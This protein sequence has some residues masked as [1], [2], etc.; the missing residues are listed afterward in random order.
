MLQDL[1]NKLKNKIFERKNKWM[2]QLQ[3]KKNLALKTLLLSLTLLGGVYTFITFAKES[4][5]EEV[6]TVKKPLPNDI[7]NI[8][9]KQIEDKKQLQ[10]QYTP[11]DVSVWEPRADFLNL[12]T[13]FPEDADTSDP[14]Q[15]YAAMIF[16]ELIETDGA[17]YSQVIS[18]LDDKPEQMASK[19]GKQRQS[20][21]GKYNITDKEQ[22]PLNKDTWTVKKWDD[23][24]VK[25]RDANGVDLQNHSNLK[26]IMAMANVYGYY[27]HWDDE[28]Q[29]LNYT[30]QLL[31]ASKSYQFSMSDISFEKEMLTDAEIIKAREKGNGQTL[32]DAIQAANYVNDVQ[33]PENS[34]LASPSDAVSDTAPNA[35]PN[36]DTEQE[37]DTPK[38]TSGIGDSVPPTDA[39]DNKNTDRNT[40]TET[41]SVG[42]ETT[43]SLDTSSSTDEGESG[44]QNSADTE[45]ISTSTSPLDEFSLDTD[46]N[47]RF[48]KNTGKLD[49]KLDLTV[50]QLNG[51]NSLY[52]LDSIGNSA[53]NFNEH[54]QGWTEDKK[55]LV[56]AMVLQNWYAEYGINSNSF[57]TAK[58]LSKLE[59]DTY[60]AELPS[61]LSEVRRNVIKTAL[62]S[63][64]YIP[65]Y[66]GG[67]PISN[68]YERNQFHNIVAPDYKGR[69]FRGLDCSGWVNYV[70]WSATGSKPAA[71]STGAFLHSGH[72]IDK[73]NLRPGDVLV[74]G[75]FEETVGHIV[76]FLKWN[77]DG[78]MKVIE[79]TGFPQNNV[80]ISDMDISWS[81]RN[82]LD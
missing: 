75:G 36:T 31:L 73:A 64:G 78:S 50:Y 35:E 65:Y 76:I 37:S 40:S 61:D 17:W 80:T 9:A 14:T 32:L 24:I 13:K 60:L 62:Q 82:I 26:E 46:G 30:K 2:T 52:T 28:E 43:S 12:I 54:W 11:I 7:L 41:E 5:V 53:E 74:R 4:K 42:I 69:V 39:F 34:T 23:V 3:G 68:E 6:V 29:F 56:D 47:V 55:A 25:V 49:L 51:K 16:K 19:L 72:A 38:N 15:S 18:G 1:K 8:I 48:P 45:E 67:K 27:H 71:A 70:L 66:F 81:C 63:V 33:N 59:M 57:S 77:A 44:E 10:L 22:D 58:P 79:E 21:L 20:V